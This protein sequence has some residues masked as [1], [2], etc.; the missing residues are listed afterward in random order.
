[1]Y[2]PIYWLP[3]NKDAVMLIKGCY[4]CAME[5]EDFITEGGMEGMYLF[6]LLTARP[7]SSKPH[8]NR[9]KPHLESLRLR[10]HWCFLKTEMVFS[11]I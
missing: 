6:G 10:K 4:K 2:E 3:M 7:G 1:M 5:D 8:G 9:I 11:N